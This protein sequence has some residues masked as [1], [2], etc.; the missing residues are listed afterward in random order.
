MVGG[1]T[2]AIASMPAQLLKIP[3]K[4]LRGAPMAAVGTVAGGAIGAVTG[5]VSG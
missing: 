3:F 1:V 2:G 4:K 5:G